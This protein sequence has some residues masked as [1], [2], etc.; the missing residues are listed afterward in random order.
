MA[1]S[2]KVRKQDQRDREAAQL[3]EI[4]AS[5]FVANFG[6]GVFAALDRVVEAGG[7]EHQEEAFNV[8]ILNADKLINSDSHVFERLVD[9]KNIRR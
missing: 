2:D 6:S 9:V 5:K 8:L 3:L 4:G 7:F 1:K